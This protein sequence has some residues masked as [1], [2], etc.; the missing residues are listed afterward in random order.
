MVSVTVCLRDMTKEQ[1]EKKFGWLT[2]NDEP[3]NMAVATRQLYYIHRPTQADIPDYGDM[4]NRYFEETKETSDALEHLENIAN[5]FVNEEEAILY[6]NHNSSKVR[7][8]AL[9]I[10]KYGKEAVWWLYEIWP[11]SL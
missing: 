7:A 11:S 3:A 10:V 1:W 9:N 8:I 2:I 4:N 6:V 5:G